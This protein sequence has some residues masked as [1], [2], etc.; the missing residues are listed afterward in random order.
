MNMQD[1]KRLSAKIEFDTWKC[2]NQEMDRLYSEQESAMNHRRQ[3]AALKQFKSTMARLQRGILGHVLDAFRHNLG[4]A[5]RESQ[6]KKDHAMKQLSMIIGGIF[7]GLS[8]TIFHSWQSNMA[9]SVKCRTLELELYVTKAADEHN[10]EVQILNEGISHAEKL[11]GLMQD[12]INNHI[13]SI[14]DLEEALRLSKDEPN[15]AKRAL[16]SI[17]DQAHEDAFCAGVRE[18]MLE[19]ENLTLRLKTA[20]RQACLIME[21]NFSRG[22]R[23]SLV[24]WRLSM[25][26]SR[27]S[28]E[29]ERCYEAHE[30]DLYE[31]EVLHAE[32]VEQCEADLE[33]WKQCANTIKAAAETAF[34]Q[35]NVIESDYADSAGD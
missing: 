19:Q 3:Q 15:E 2:T 27:H 23:L 33:K 10:R 30:E 34:A 24:A 8:F 7:K 12:M 17:K 21:R 14:A 32:I 18:Q 6:I 13:S 20:G 11:L 1:Y 25:S 9:N 26:D 29:M 31:Q 22:M 28:M 4:I 16:A 5:L 35:D